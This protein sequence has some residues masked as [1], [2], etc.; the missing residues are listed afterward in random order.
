MDIRHLPNDHPDFPE[1][2]KQIP[3]PPQAI[4]VLGDLAAVL[5]QPRLAVVG[6]RKVTPYGKLV[7]N[8]LAG[9]AAGRGI[10]I[11]SGLALG[12]DALAHKAALEAGGL[13]LAVLANGLDQITPSSNYWLGQEILKRG[14]ALVSEYAP[15]SPP[16]KLNF[17]AR[18][19]LVAGLSNAILV[20]EAAAQS[21]TR[22]TVEFALDQGNIVLAVPGNINSPMS[23]GTNK[24]LKDGA[25]VVTTVDDIS[26]A[27]GLP[28]AQ[29][30]LVS[31]SNAAETAIL[32][33]IELGITDS[34]DLLR[35]S[36][37]DAPQFNQTLTMLE[38]TGRIQALGARQWGFK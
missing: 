27:M 3:D 22:H 13:T 34:S 36:K 8:Q 20:T 21:G 28:T 31:G 2:L 10:A 19:R 14:G 33:L 15:G 12:V 25:L 16:F 24:A 6:T 30:V 1:C 18:N 29:A 32:E 11:V 4:Y 38:I 37:L 17:V 9:Q 7:T 26:L 35:L 23:E 5:A